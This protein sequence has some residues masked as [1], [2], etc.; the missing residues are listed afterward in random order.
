MSRLGQEEEGH[1][2]DKS[3]KFRGAESEFSGAGEERSRSELVWQ[4]E[5]GVTDET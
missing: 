5:L 1:R 2:N 3:L 4:P